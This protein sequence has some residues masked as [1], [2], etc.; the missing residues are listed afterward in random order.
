MLVEEAG[1]PTDKEQDDDYV[2]AEKPF[3]QEQDWTAL[4]R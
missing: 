2:V 1:R 3:F 4:V